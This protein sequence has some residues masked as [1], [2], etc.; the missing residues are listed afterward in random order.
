MSNDIAY[1]LAEIDDA[2][3][4][5]KDFVKDGRRIIDIYNA[6]N[7]DKVPFNI[8]FSNTDTLL[9]ALYSAIPRPVIKRR[10]KDDDPLGKA[11]EIAAT[12]MLEF[13]L[14]TNIDGYETFDEGM[15]NATLDA[16]LPG[17]GVTRIKY[18]AEILTNDDESASEDSEDQEIYS[19]QLKKEAE[20]VCIDA[21]VWDRVLFGYSK[22]WSTLPWIAFEEYIDKPEAIRLFGAAMA[23]NIV[24]L[25]DNDSNNDEDDED[26]DDK[27]GSEDE[28]QGGRKTACI[29]QIWDRESKK[30][31]YVSRSYT[32]DF[33]KVEDD[34]LG[35]TGFFPIP[36]P[37]QFIEKSHDISSTAPYLVY[38]NQAK[39]LSDLTRRINRL[40]KAIKAKGIYD[41]ELGDDIANLMQ[42]DDN[43]F[44]P[45]DKSSALA[46]EKG[47]QNAI[48]FL[49][50]REMVS[51]LSEL[52]QAREQCKQVIY[53]VTGISDI[54]RGSTVAS[55]TA[56]AQ[57]I[58]SQ[59]GT[60]RLKRSQKEVQRYARD[61]LRIM[62]EIAATKFSEE[63]WSS[64]TGLPYSTEQQVQQA[65]MIMQA[66]QQYGQQ[67]PPQFQNTL[68]QAQQILQAPSWN[69]VLGLLK[70]DLQRAYRIDIETNSTI[71]PEASEDQK[72][73]SEV[74][75]A[76]GQYLQGI[77][78][79][80]QSGSF[81]F[82]GAKAMMMT[83][84]RR[85]QFGDEIE[86]YI[87]SMQPPQPPPVP[88]DTSAQDAQAAA[89][90]QQ[91][92]QA[93]E[94]QLKQA[95]MQ[96]QQQAD[97]AKL[98]AQRLIEQGKAAT[99]LQLAQMKID[100]DTAIAKYKADL[101]AQV[102]LELAQMQCA[103]QDRQADKQ[104][105]SQVL[106]SRLNQPNDPTDE[107]DE[108]DNGMQ[109]ILATITQAIAMMA[110]PKH[111][112]LIRDENG[113][114]VA[115]VEQPIEDNNGSL[116]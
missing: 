21:V 89:Q 26:D 3:K 10:F 77:N 57:N 51:V 100:S 25:R 111:T 64:M 66:A 114:A 74:M 86:D 48:W 105:A 98:E 88:P 94:Q 56:T 27:H 30:V 70:D 2:K 9:P 91:A 54:I 17:R 32:K 59:W 108:D 102:K 81:P 28:H 75:T 24:F 71:L 85:F 33:L 19:G 116:Q 20:L 73:I 47:F 4:R 97:A 15:R 23:K 43:T 95:D 109:E 90:A 29:Y 62:L 104:H 36:K 87:K 80:V 39:E 42:G 68:Q 5:D 103:A 99:E 65:Q 72:N 8:L 101:D 12:R 60:M 76:L 84:V 44:V 37:I 110:K 112:V 16:L 79:L 93:H 50:I 67:I 34:P 96:A 14:D 69:Q 61:M 35:L 107:P 92:Q 49:P 18:D 13:L 40:V 1:W 11:S 7:P 55:E 6:N 58:K 31:I 82:E 22:K 53:E 106:L 83:V 41:A 113:R 115:S 45:A 46:A 63:S 38:E 52:Y 78:P